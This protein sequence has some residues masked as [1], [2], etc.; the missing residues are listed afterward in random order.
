MA[1]PSGSSNLLRKL[2]I[3][4]LREH[5]VTPRALLLAQ[6]AADLLNGASAVGYLLQ[7]GKP[8]GWR[9][10]AVVGDI[11]LESDLVPLD[12]GSLGTLFHEGKTMLFQGS[13]L[14][15]EDYA[16]L[17]ATRTLVS[18]A[19][20]P[21]VARGEILGAMQVASFGNTIGIG[22]L[23]VLQELAEEGG[24]G[25]SSALDYEKE[26]NTHLESISRLAQ[27][28]DLEKVFNSTLDLQTLL[29]VVAS[30][31]REVLEVQA[32]N[33]WMV[34]D[35]D[36]LILMSRAGVDCTVA[37]G[38]STR[39]GEGLV[40]DV[41][42]TG[43][44][45]LIDNPADAYLVTR[46]A[47]IDDGQIFSAMASPMVVND[48]QIGVVEAINKSDG[49]PFDDD[50]LFFLGSLGETAATAFQ[51][52][53][54]LQAERKLEILKTLVK[55]STEITST[56]DL[57]RVLH[58]IVNTPSAVIGYDRAAIALEQR[59][60]HQ[61]KAVSGMDQVH[62]GDPEIEHLQELLEWT[63]VLDHPVLVTSTDGDIQTDR[64]ETRA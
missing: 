52:A 49:T 42:D 60:R 7:H 63:S 44:A 39:K 64:E 8:G 6:E 18:L 43:E 10:K 35:Q 20:L 24:V 9:V 4:L 19:C 1:T 21:I 28:Y 45:K 15:R 34:K 25:L 58:A 23:D 41:S 47:G 29:P 13:E 32:V 26:R 36:E 56:L 31:F 59:G 27:L 33:V 53:S 62:T 48:Q 40:A 55:V 17:H 30:K 11:H 14:V 57:D 54:L 3:S 37:E 50:D 38:S 51:N 2:R 5:E 16:H 61:L 12:A 46:N 22:D